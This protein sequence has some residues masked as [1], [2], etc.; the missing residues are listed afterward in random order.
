MTTA[1]D[2]GWH[3]RCRYSAIRCAREAAN[4]GELRDADCL[5][6]GLHS[7]FNCSISPGWCNAPFVGEAHSGDRP[8][9]G[10][11]IVE[12]NGSVASANVFTL[13]YSTTRG[14]LRPSHV[15]HL[16]FASKPWRSLQRRA[17]LWP[18][19]STCAGLLW[20]M[21]DGPVFS[22]F[23]HRLLFKSRACS[24]ASLLRK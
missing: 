17:F 20:S 9:A 7:S 14:A 8:T 24:T 13:A 2:L 6:S 1:E 4:P 23:S 21:D 12:R 11:P 16:R 15:L 3:G 22:Y 19:F 5:P 10:L 18:S